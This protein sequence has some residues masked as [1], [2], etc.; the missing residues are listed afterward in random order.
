M[1]RIAQA[2]RSAGG[3]G[4]ALVAYLTAGFPRRE[5]FLATLDAVAGAADVV[6]I[7][8]PFSD[9][10]ADG[11]TIQRSSRVAL[12]QGVTLAW[13]LETLTGPHRAIK[14]PLLLMSYFNPLLAFGV[15]ALPDAASRAGISGFI[16]PDLPLE[17]SDDLRRAL[18]R[19]GIALVQFVAPTTPPARAARLCAASEG[20][21]YALTMNGVTGRN[22]ALAESTLAWL[23]QLKSS[24]EIPV[25]A[26]FGIRHANQV[27]RLAPHVDGVI[28]G[29]ALVEVLERGEDPGE[30]LRSLRAGRSSLAAARDRVSRG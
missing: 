21:V 25:C 30:F 7:G 13:L 16:V 27:A 19:E 12:D 3:D 6:E 10:M 20:F 14:V 17:E 26:G 22:A 2:I 24:A 18:S 5:D 28:V 4:P 23:A 9:P 29:S 1:N 11:L 8:V 15:E